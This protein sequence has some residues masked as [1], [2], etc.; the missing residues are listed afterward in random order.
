MT[1][2]VK[3]KLNT[4]KDITEFVEVS[5]QFPI[6]LDVQSGRYIVSA[7]SIMGILSLNLEEVVNLVF[8]N[9]YI[10]DIKLK[11]NKWIVN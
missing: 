8:D 1:E 11:F 9:N 4:I 5:R 7:T 10:E 6:E 2:R 3:I